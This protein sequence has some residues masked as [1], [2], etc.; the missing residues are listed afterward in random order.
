MLM[1]RLMLVTMSKHPFT[2]TGDA[3]IDEDVRLRALNPAKSFIVQAPAGSGKT[4]LLITR[5]LTLLAT[6]DEPEEIVAITFTRKAAAEMRQRI[7]AALAA[8]LTTEAQA[9]PTSPDSLQ[10]AAAAALVRDR[11]KGWNIAQSPSRFRIQT[12]DAFNANLARQAPLTTRFG[13]QPQTSE[14]P[15]ALYAEAARDVLSAL[16]DRNEYSTAIATLLLHLDN[17]HSKLC[18]L[19]AQMLAK[20]DQWLRNFPGINVASQSA[21]LRDGLQRTLVGQRVAKFS[22][23]DALFSHPELPSREQILSHFNYARR[24]LELREMSVFAGVS[25]NDGAR[26]LALAESF[27]TKTDTIRKTVNVSNGFP[28]TGT[29]AKPQKEAFVATLK[30]LSAIPNATEALAALRTLPAAQ[31]TDAEWKILEAAWQLLPYAVGCLWQVFARHGQCDFTEVALAADRA[32]GTEDTPTDLAL[33]LDVAIAHILVDEFQDTSQ[34]QYNLLHRLTAQ[35][36]M[37]EGR[38]LFLVGDPMQSIY[39]FREAKVG[40]F[41]NAQQNGLGDVVLTPC[42]LTLNFRSHPAIISWINNTFSKLIGVGSSGGGGI[43]YLPSATPYVD[44]D[45]LEPAQYGATLHAIA[46][47]PTHTTADLKAIEAANVVACI[48]AAR[49]QDATGSIAILVRGRTHLTQILPALRRATIEY[50]AHDLD[51]LDQRA[52]VQ[53]CIALTRALLHDSDRTAW[54]G[55]LRAPWCGLSLAELDALFGLNADAKLPNSIYQQLQNIEQQGSANRFSPASQIALLHFKQAMH[56]ARTN[57]RR[58]SLRDCVE[59]CWLSLK[60]PACCREDR[61][62]ADVSTYFDCLESAEIAGNLINFD[63]LAEALSGRF[64]VAPVASNITTPA[65]EIMTIHKAKGLEF[66]TVIVPGLNQKSANDRP[67]LLLWQELDD[68]HH[69]NNFMPMLLAPIAEGAVEPNKDA[70]QTIY[71]YLTQLS[72]AQQ[73]QEDIRLLYVAATRAAKR[74]HLLA[75]IKIDVQKLDADLK[76]APNSLLAA[77]WPALGE[78]FATLAF[79][80]AHEV[81]PKIESAATLFN[82]SIEP[83]RLVREAVGPSAAQVPRAHT[84]HNWQHA[85]AQNNIARHTGTVIH[86]WLAHIADEGAA[87][88]N[89]AKIGALG[90]IIAQRLASLGI[91]NNPQA[92]AVVQTQ[93]QSCLNSQRG[94]WLLQP[95]ARAK[96]EWQLAGNIEGNIIHATID[97]S[98]VDEAGVRWIVDYKTAAPAA[99]ED[100]QQFLATQQQQYES[101]LHQYAVL[102]S[103]LADTPETTKIMLALYFPSI[104]S[105]Q[106]WPFCQ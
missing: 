29:D 44:D 103:R 78:R 69:D 28:A 95:H 52:V 6:V 22:A 105:W 41:L 86:E 39:R 102:V 18:G 31:Y 11:L 10:R 80:A 8:G 45:E 14:R 37:D 19:V 100:L 55:C 40:L 76:P 83:Q 13:A 62:L 4:R 90:A 9:T 98:F 48:Q 42:A 91:L 79:K 16:D 88:W 35:W 23:A 50:V 38:T 46:Q 61:D 5:Y 72:N 53:D 51:R 67:E 21:Q 54:L 2:L 58:Q 34:A 36:G 94:Q 84:N 65:V 73:R 99:E 25:A 89:A 3:L 7:Q 15:Q 43:S 70:P 12:I 96:S 68:D 104:D 20:R 26:W 97:R 32:L 49:A 93:L 24:N 74:L 82:A 27:L 30:T 59:Q 57:F 81:M 87:S 56:A 33:K 63:T 47:T 101:Q 106:Q 85:N 71:R 17:D 77:L 1:T 64:S 92:V 60:G 66:D 75:C